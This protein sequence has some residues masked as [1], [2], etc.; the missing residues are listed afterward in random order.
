MEQLAKRVGLPEGEIVSAD[1]IAEWPEGKLD[2]LVSAGILTEI[3]HSK[4]V[5]CN[6]CAEDCYIEPEIK[7]LPTGETVGVFVCTRNPDIG[8]VEIALSRL[9]RW[10]TSKKRLAQLGYGSVKD[11]HRTVTRQQRKEDDKLQMRA[12]L[13]RHHGFDTDTFGHEPATQKQLQ[14]L[15]NW[16]QTKVHRVM[17]TIFGDRPMSVYKT[18]CRAKTIT[19]FLRKADDGRYTPEAV[20]D[21]ADQ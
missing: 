4:G 7:K 8:R 10:K 9:R 18:R 11:K 3:E 5:V 6:E 1:E 2:E 16:S 19:G 21:P 13:L 15:T 14:K 20:S 17:K 12:A